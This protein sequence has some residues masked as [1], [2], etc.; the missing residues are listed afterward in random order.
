MELVS[1]IIPYYKKKKYFYKSFLS[2]Y[3]QTYK[4]KEIIIIYDDTD[5]SDLFYIKNLIIKY[6]NTK[7]IIN[8]KNIGAGLSRNKGIKF[9]KGKY[10]AFLDSDDLWHKK[11]LTN[12][13]QF[14]KKNNANFSHTSYKILNK[15]NIVVG[16]QIAPNNISYYNLLNS[17]DIG[18]STVVV[19]KD[20]LLK[21]FFT[22]LTTKEDYA[23][24]LK[25]SKNHKIF[26]I[27]AI[28]CNWRKLENSLSVGIFK[29]LTNGFKVYYIYEELNFFISIYRVLILSLFYT[30]KRI[31]QKYN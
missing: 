15:N 16:R 5:K 4:K 29:K 14:M 7:L 26:G 2:A 12:Q 20:I 31:K 18:L 27:K 11:K 6:K 17:C 25:I 13:L 3:N 9:S 10:I 22:N 30:F 28:L 8:K 19:K 1:I 23:L 24:W 21:N